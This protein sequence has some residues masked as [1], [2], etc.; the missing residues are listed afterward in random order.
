MIGCGNHI[1]KNPIN[2]CKEKDPKLKAKRCCICI[3][4][5]KKKYFIAT[6]HQSHPQ[7]M[8]NLDTMITCDWPPSHY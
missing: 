1:E 7:L 2:D 3:S 4:K 6:P 8:I 5:K